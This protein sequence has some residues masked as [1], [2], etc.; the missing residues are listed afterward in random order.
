M[1]IEDFLKENK[2]Y[3]PLSKGS[4]KK[5]QE[6]LSNN[7]TLI[8][9]LNANVSTMAIDG[10]LKNKPFSIKNKLNGVI[11]LTNKRIFFCNSVLGTINS[12]QIL[13]KDIQ[14]IDDII[15]PIA[16]S[17][18]RIQGITEMFVI[19][20]NKNVLQIFKDK[21]NDV[22]NN[23]NSGDNDSNLQI[24]IADEIKKYKDLLDS[25]AI[26]QEEYELLKQK[27]IK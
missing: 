13:I 5:A 8:Y 9:A 21:I 26:N 23:Y 15:N 27:L 10:K 4:M 19:D 12:K 11:A 18:L 20:L 14:S 6:M 22:I 16:M 7:E 2:T 17:T 24:N 25:G 1:K 3:N